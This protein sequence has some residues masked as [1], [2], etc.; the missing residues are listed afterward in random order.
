M[1]AVVLAVS[2]S[3]SPAF[4]HGGGLDDRGC[5]TDSS[6]GEYHCH[7]GPLE[8][9]SFESQAAAARALEGGVGEGGET[10]GADARAYDRDLYGDWG[11]ADGDCQDTRDEVLADQGRQIELSGNGCEVVDGVWRG[12]YTGEAFTDPGNLHIDHVVPLQEAH[13]SG[14]RI[15]PASTRRR[16]ANDPGNLLAVEAG[17]NM[18]KGC[19]GPADWLPET[20]QCEYVRQWVTV[21]RDWDLEIDRG[22]QAAVESALEG[23]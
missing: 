2:T 9:R 22:E 17:A 8:G 16:F 20:G 4:A 14:A 11:D 15:W 13:I 5:H 7:Q 19:R 1:A 21:K 10:E 3:A 12:P 23:C 6:R 18:R